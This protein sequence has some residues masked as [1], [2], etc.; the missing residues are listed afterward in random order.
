MNALKQCPT[1]GRLRIQNREQTMTACLNPKCPEVY[2][3]IPIKEGG[4]TPADERL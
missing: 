2:R 3:W 1:C 4:L